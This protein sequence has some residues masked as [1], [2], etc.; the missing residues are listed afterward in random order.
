MQT[1]DSIRRDSIDTATLDADPN[2][3]LVTDRCRYFGT[4]HA[5]LWEYTN[6]HLVC[7]FCDEKRPFTP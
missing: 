1:T 3:T 4:P 5:H 2:P 7:A 6:G